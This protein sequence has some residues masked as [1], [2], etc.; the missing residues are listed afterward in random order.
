MVNAAF[1]LFISA[2][3]RLLCSLDLPLT[4]GEVANFV[5]L[6]LVMEL[7]LLVSFNCCLSA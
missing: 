5:M 3:T 1:W 6:K 2:Y 7:Q 4:Y